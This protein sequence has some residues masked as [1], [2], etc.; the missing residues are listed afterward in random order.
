MRRGI[1]LGLGIVLGALLGAGMMYVWDPDR[2]RRRR[3]IARMR[4]RRRSRQVQEMGG[5]LAS[6]SRHVRNRLRGRVIEAQAAWRGEAVPDEILIERIRARIGHCSDHPRN[7]MVSVQ[8]GMV[9]ISGPILEREV[10]AVIRCVQG[11]RGVR[12][13]TN[14]LEVHASPENLPAL[15]E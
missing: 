9:T 7:I 13:L 3:A 11:V 10:D 6:G 15:Q 2:G 12:G 5:R 8:N 14:R 4:A 1:G